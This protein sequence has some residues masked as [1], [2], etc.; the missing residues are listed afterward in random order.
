M[1]ISL[2]HAFQS[3]KGD[4]TDATRVQ[5][6]NWNAEHAITL[7][8]DSLVGRGST[9]GAAVEITCTAFGRTLIAS[10]DQAAARTAL[11]AAAASDVAGL[12]SRQIIAGAGLTGGGALSAD[13]TLIVNFA[14]AAEWRNNTAGKVLGTEGVWSAMAE[15]ALTDGATVSW[16]MNS[17]FDFALTLG[18]NRAI[19]NPTNPKV[20]QKGRLFLIQDAGGSRTVTWGANFKF[21]GGVKPTLSTAAGAVDL[22]YY[23]VRATNFIV[24]TQGGRA[25]A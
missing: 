11:A 14:S 10:A 22:F 9:A 21:A 19:A 1:T 6:S 7:A 3:T 16:D 17:G 13:R 2:K 12:L 4:G 23:D 24:V 18:G 8:A 25:F 5:P 15:V 20:G